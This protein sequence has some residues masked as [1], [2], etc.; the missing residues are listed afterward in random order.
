MQNIRSPICTVVGH[1]D[2]GKSTFLDKIRGSSI[3]DTE[4]GQ[5]TQAIGASLIP[6]STVRQICGPLVERM[7]MKIT[8]QGLLFIDTPGHAA[9]SSLRK[10]GGTIADIAVLVVDINEGFKPQTI[11]AIEM[12]KQFRVPFVVAANKLDLIQGWV[13]KENDICFLD[14]L[15]AQNENAQQTL[16]RK[17]YETVGKLFEH[18]FNSERFDRVSDYTKQIAIV[19]ISAKMGIGIQET[20]MVIAGL[21]QKFLENNLR[22]DVA[23]PAKGTI[24]EI[25]NI[26][27]MGTCIDLII[28]D[29]ILKAGDIIVIGDMEKPIVTKVRAIF[30]PAP[31]SETRDAKSKFHSVKES[32]AASA[33]RLS[34]PD[35]ENAVAGMPLRAATEETLEAAK[36]AVQK[37]VKEVILETDKNGIIVKADTL[38]SLEALLNMLRDRKIPLRKAAVGNISKKDISDAESNY[39]ENPLDS[40]ILGF[41]VVVP[42]DV[43]QLQ[44][45]KIFTN[46]IIYKLIEDFEKWKILN[47]LVN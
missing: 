15:K 44:K 9:F 28:Y 20:L 40:V 18:G 22:L 7:N 14:A 24:L 32:K 17:L 41:N 27:G 47:E 8:I 3:V 34:A 35:V 37:E 2:H 5:I 25:K 31:L 29:G 46:N 19:P 13:A 23:G 16:D 6:I 11:E 33:V 43:V 30:E 36:E 12:L 1:V 45:V 10:R 42:P 21:A 39:D 4:P 26:K 38:G